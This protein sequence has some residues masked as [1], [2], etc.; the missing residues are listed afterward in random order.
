MRYLV[1]LKP[2][3]PFFFG[4]DITF[5]E[6]TKNSNY[7]V[8]SRLFP[9]QTAILGMIRK[10]ILIQSKLLTTKRQGEWVDDKSSATKL[11]GDTKFSFNQEQNFGVLKSISPIFL[12]QNSNRFI[13]KVD[14]DS[15]TYQKGLLKGYDPK[16]DI[17]DN[18][19]SIDTKQTKNMSDIFI[20]IEQIGIK[21]NSDKE[22]YFKKTS[23]LLKDDFQF[24]FY[25]ELDF[26]LQKSFITLG[27]EQ[28]MFKMDIQKSNQELDYY[29]KNGYLTL[30]SDSYIDIPIRDNCEFAIT[31]EISFSF[32]VNKFKDNKKVFKKHNKE[33]FFYE[34]GSV[35][36]NPTPQLIENINKPNLQKIGYNIFTQGE[37]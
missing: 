15:C 33:Y 7:L 2:L 12:I 35:F 28:S 21:K 34:K 13:K 10:E 31:S 5:G 25:I 26:E 18:Y 4:G 24:A 29:D 20:P 9:Q 19:I 36:I 14:I 22:G 23:Y 11:V 37:K 27:A 1:T 32:L 30:L 17:Y 16:K 3:K 6:L 8:H